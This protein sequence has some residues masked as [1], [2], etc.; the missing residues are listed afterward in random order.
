MVA[1]AP[2]QIM[3]QT[4]VVFLGK[5]NA[6]NKV[7]VIHTSPPSPDLPSSDFGRLTLRRADF[8]YKF[9]PSF[10]KPSLDRFFR[11]KPDESASGNHGSSG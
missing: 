10:D 11:A 5:I 7:C 3:G 2:L 1:Q 8:A 9:L 4:N 6:L